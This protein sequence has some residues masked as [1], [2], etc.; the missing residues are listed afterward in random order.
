MVNLITY[1][2]NYLTTESLFSQMSVLGAPWSAEIGQDMDDAYF[3]MY[4]GLKPA[5]MFVAMHSLN[6]V[7]NA[8]TIARIV[9]SMYKI[10]WERLWNA[11]QTE[12][13]PIDNYNIKENITR[14]KTSD[15]TIDRTTS[16]KNV[17]S[18]E[19]STN[20]GQQIETTA[21]SDTYTFAF[22]DT[23]RTPTGAVDETGSET[24]SGTDTTNTSS[25]STT[26][27]SEDTSDKLGEDETIN[28]TRVGNVG[29]N[30]YQE[31]MRQEF[32]LWKWNFFT[33]VFEDVDRFLTLSVYDACRPVNYTDDM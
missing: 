16:D 30:S 18:G 8:L 15:R 4:S 10:P 20:Y 1:F 28:R 32:E 27:G 11:Y 5:S 23:T 7:A 33:R 31:L 19:D 6:G 13:S 14:N 22:N 21:S 29:Q 17:S 9:L 3:T 2:P 24:H 26:T 25:T 12:Y